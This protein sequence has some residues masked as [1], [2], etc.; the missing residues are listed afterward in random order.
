MPKTA[1]NANVKKHMT[2]LKSCTK[3]NRKAVRDYYK[4]SENL[5]KYSGT[6]TKR[7]EALYNKSKKAD[8]KSRKIQA[9]CV[10]VR[11]ALEDMIHTGAVVKSE[12]K[13]KI[14]QMIN[15]LHKTE[16]EWSSNT[17]SFKRMLM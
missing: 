6:S 7:R 10:K 1:E 4:A 3:K 9:E 12:N 14:E 17:S 8:L 2:K 15:K 13:T 5:R 16:S 11:D